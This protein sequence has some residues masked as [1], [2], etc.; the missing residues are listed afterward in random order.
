MHGGAD[1]N[2]DPP[3]RQERYRFHLL[4]RAV[5]INQDSGDV[6]NAAPSDVTRVMLEQ[7]CAP[8]YWRLGEVCLSPATGDVELADEKLWPAERRAALRN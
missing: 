3:P 2:Q 5:C 7:G 4:T 6:V 1:G 8:G